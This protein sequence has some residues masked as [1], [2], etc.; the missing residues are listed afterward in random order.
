MSVVSDFPNIKW[1]DFY[2]YMISNYGH[3]TYK[4][5]DKLRTPSTHKRGYKWIW[6]VIP[7]KGKKKL[8][9]HRVVAE[10]FIPN[11]DN[12]PQVNH[13]DGDKTNNFEGNLE[14]VTNYEN[15]QHAVKNNLIAKGETLAKKLTWK[16]VAQ[17]R[18]EYVRNSSTKGQYALARKYGVSQSVIMEILRNNIWKL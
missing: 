8:L 15:R 14:W 1:S 12:L 5:S 4:N 18:K 11:P 7:S 2:G 9:M 17:I 13:I 6:F 16:K 3:V 10:L